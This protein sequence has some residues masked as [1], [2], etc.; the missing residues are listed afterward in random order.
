MKAG[1]RETAEPELVPAAWWCEPECLSEGV[2][3]ASARGE[4]WLHRER[5]CA[6]H[7]ISRPVAWG[8]FSGHSIQ[9]IRNW[10]HL[11]GEDP[12]TAVRVN[13]AGHVG[14]Y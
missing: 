12:R 14:A 9:G 2:G 11:S 10:N 6:P 8:R 13:V 5:F 1:N 3:T 7:R 4:D